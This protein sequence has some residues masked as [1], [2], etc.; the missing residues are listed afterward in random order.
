MDQAVPVASAN[1]TIQ[2]GLRVVAPA[3]ASGAVKRRRAPMALAER[4]Q[5]DRAAIRLLARLRDRHG[6]GPLRLRVP[7]RSVAVVLSAG[8]VGRLL[9]GAP[10]PF[11]PGNAE[12][13]AALGRF[14]GA[15]APRGAARAERRC[16]EAVLEP[17]QSLHHLA[18][19]LLPGLHGEVDLLTADADR[20]GELDWR[21]FDR[22]WQR[23]VRLLVFG[24]AARED[25][26]LTAVLD[27][28]RRSGN[29]SYPGRRR[30][31]AREAFAARLRRAIGDAGPGTLAEAVRESGADGAAQPED[32]AVHP[33]D[34]VAR[35]L[36]AF[37]A[38]GIALARTLALLAVHPGHL[39]AAL[40]EL[41][42]EDPAEPAELPFLRAC[43]LDSLRLWPTTPMLLRDGTEA[44]AWGEGDLPGGTAFLVY[45]PLFH[46]D[47]SRPYADRF[48]PD[49]WLDGTAREDPALVPFSGGPARCPGRNLVLFCATSA[50]ARLLREREWR[51]S[52]P[53][54]ML[55]GRPVPATLDHF[56]LAFRPEPARQPLLGG[57]A[58]TSAA[59]GVA[60][61]GKPG[62]AG[63]SRRYGAVC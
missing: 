42:A 49:I 53:S 21:G 6:P 23:T 9:E 62:L 36:F 37:D 34:Q 17:H 59:P 29:W 39:L 7:G 55:A 8:H 31:R 47:P 35:W 38:A 41:A 51:L 45:T 46:R 24:E 28:L 22:A 10:E 14:H 60:P 50:L 56:G 61:F 13:H 15:L 40:N 48:A 63:D 25:R 2:I 58:H 44:T 5:A 16:N 30:I 11:T 32:G 4:F 26:K 54:P 1:E 12:K 57:D 20:R 19:A 52:S 43:V 33:E 18:P 3:V 27:S